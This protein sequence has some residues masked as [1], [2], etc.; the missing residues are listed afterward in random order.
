M[1]FIPNDVASVRKNVNS[2]LKNIERHVTN[3][4]L[5][6]R[7]GCDIGDIFEEFLKCQAVLAEA[8]D[9]DLS[10]DELLDILV[11]LEIGLLWH[12]NNHLKYL[13]KYFPKLTSAVANLSD[14]EVVSD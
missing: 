13:K 12:V 4:K 11:K 5:W 2:L 9:K 6:T 1:N 7:F 3:E 14:D 8:A 10:E